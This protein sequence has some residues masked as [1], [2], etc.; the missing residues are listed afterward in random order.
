[1]QRGRTAQHLQLV[2]SFLVKV[3]GNPN[4]ADVFVEVY[5]RSPSRDDDTDVSFYKELRKMSRTVVLVLMGDFIFQ[6]LNRTMIQ[7]TPA[8][9]GNS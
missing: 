7:Q 5:Y 9:P 8:G 3:G 1:M 6:M 2:E 4:K